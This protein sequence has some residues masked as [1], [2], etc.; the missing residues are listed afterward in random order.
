VHLLEASQHVEQVGFV[1]RA[2]LAVDGQQTFVRPWLTRPDWCSQTTNRLT[3]VGAHAEGTAL[4]PKGPFSDHQI[5]R[6]LFRRPPDN[7]QNFCMVA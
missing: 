1:P 6:R 4:V 2:V 5:R 3:S 7:G